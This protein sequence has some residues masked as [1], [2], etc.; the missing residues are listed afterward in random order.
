MTVIKCKAECSYQYDGVCARNSI[1]VWFGNGE[2]PECKSFEEKQY[3]YRCSVCN[4]VVTS[5]QKRYDW[6]CNYCIG[7]ME[8]MNR[9]IRTK[10]NRGASGCNVYK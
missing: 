2:R 4:M 10:T 3:R 5:N 8:L 7:R 1:D 9:Q 6:G